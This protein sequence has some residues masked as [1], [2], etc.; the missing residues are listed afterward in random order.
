MPVNVTMEEPR[1]S[2]VRL[3]SE[4]DIVGSSTNVQHVASDGVGIVVHGASCG[5]DDVKGVLQ[6]RERQI[7]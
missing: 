6:I 2:V 3:E 7:G 4:R 1:T 5:T